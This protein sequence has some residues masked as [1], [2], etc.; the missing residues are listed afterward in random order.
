VLGFLAILAAAGNGVI[1]F[2]QT[3][4]TPTAVE[5]FDPAAGAV[6][7]LVLGSEPAWSADGTRIAYSRD[8]QVYV[9]NADGSGEVAIGPGSAPSWSPDGTALA[10]SRADGL[11]ILQI[12][13][14]GLGDGTVTQL[15]FG[16]ANAL[17]PAWSPDGNTIV[18][19]TQSTLAAVPAQGGGT[20]PIPLPVQPHGGAAWSPGGDRLAFVAG[21]GQVWIANPDGSNAHQLTYTLVGA[22]SA[23]D[24]PAWSPDGGAIAWTQAS[25]LCLT[26]LSGNVRR[27]TFTQQSLPA[28]VASLPSWQ[29]STQP[30]APV[31]AAATGANNSPG[32]DWNPGVRV[33]MF[34]T[35][36]STNAV[37]LK[38]SQELVFV[39]HTA[40]PLTVVTTL[41]TERATIAPGWFFGFTAEP[42]SY[43]F[44]VTGYPDGVP[45]R[46]T[47]DVAAAGSVT[48]DQHAPIRYGAG[49]VL[50]GAA[51]GPA[52][53][54]VTVAARA[55][56]A[57]R[58]TPVA[59]VQPGSG[60][61]HVTVAPTITTR[62]RVTF[63]GAATERLLR[64]TPDLRV[65]RN[66][67]TL[68]LSLRP[69]AALAGQTVFLFRL[70]PTGAWTEVRAARLARSGGLVLRGVAPG[71]Y[72]AGFQGG[73]RYW[74]T[75]SEPFTVRR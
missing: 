24:R 20:Q 39:N 45:R 38:T 10:V 50:A 54:T 29:P 47:F 64:V 43:T 21:N 59:T 68:R 14:L 32:C 66:G 73:D 52:A 23:P 11:G 18:F 63:E 56:G 37:A 26:D 22:G 28:V 7:Q 72:Y 57:S 35:N 65:A 71:R 62:Y 61:W 31:V 42:G 53:G 69:A 17:L 27:L 1:A 67:G 2:A 8:G 9:A 19:D 33:E 16:T 51:R 3:G 58:Y 12:Y 15:T 55:A 44:T 40:N 25:D 75:A 5:A 13:R 74:S 41:H 46:G 60:R 48:I 36:V 4:A 49:T 6:H 30:S 34:D 70:G